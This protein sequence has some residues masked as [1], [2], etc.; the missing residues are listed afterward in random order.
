MS[1]T[2]TAA[3]PTW[4]DVERLSRPAW[5]HLPFA[6]FSSSS[7]PALR[8]YSD[9]DACHP[10]L[11]CLDAYQRLNSTLDVARAPGRSRSRRGW[12]Q[13]ATVSPEELVLCGSEEVANPLVELAG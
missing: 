6:L 5:P 8:G 1:V 2:K 4:Y 10:P 7:T 11:V 12:L 9:D 3:G 13:D